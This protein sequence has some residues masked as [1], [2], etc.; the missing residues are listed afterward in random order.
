M[1]W[2][3]SLSEPDKSAILK[4]VSQIPYQLNGFPIDFQQADGNF[5]IVL[6]KILS[7]HPEDEAAEEAVGTDYQEAQE[8]YE[9]VASPSPAPMSYGSSAYSET[10]YSSAP[11]QMSKNMLSSDVE[12]KGSLKF[13]DELILDGSVEGE[14]NSD[15]GHL[16]VGENA[17][18]KGEVKVRAVVVYGKVDGN[19]LVTERCE[20]KSDAEI[21]GDIRA[22]TLSIEEGAAFMG[23]SSVGAAAVAAAKSG[24]SSSKS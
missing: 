3:E 6:K 15:G 7:S 8:S 12:I 19:L 20:L 10:S 21:V 16:T 17:K 11:S 2:R 22:G 24:S 14:V 13:S 23:Q 18:I 1:N 9:E 4:F 5:G